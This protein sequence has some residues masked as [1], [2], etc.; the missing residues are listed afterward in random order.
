MIDGPMDGVSLM[1]HPVLLRV[2][3]TSSL[4]Q[5]ELVIF[6]A[7]EHKQINVSLGVKIA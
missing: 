6:R 4:T 7:G 2:I 5:L 1:R 3:C